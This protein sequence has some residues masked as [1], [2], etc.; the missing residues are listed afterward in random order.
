MTGLLFADRV[1]MRPALL[2][3]AVVFAEKLAPPRWRLSRWLAAALVYV[4]GLNS[5]FH[6]SP[7][8]IWHWLFLLLWPPLVFGAEEVRKATLRSRAARKGR[9][10]SLALGGGGREEAERWQA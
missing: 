5:A 7:L 3:A 4:P 6:Q 9:S 8:G 2:V 1:G 10:V